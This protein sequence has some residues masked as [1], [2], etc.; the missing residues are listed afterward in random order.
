[1]TANA[2]EKETVSV[3]SW[4]QTGALAAVAVTLFALHAVAVM[5]SIMREASK[6]FVTKTDAA[7]TQAVISA[8]QT[9]IENRMRDLSAELK[10]LRTTLATRDQM[11]ALQRQVDKVE[12]RLVQL[13]RD[14]K[15]KDK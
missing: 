14:G 5:P 6:E 11:A 10:D 13:E 12:D 4:K 9:A 15:P 8:S 7:A 1:M 3:Q 2:S